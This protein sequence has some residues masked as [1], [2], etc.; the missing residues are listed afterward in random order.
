MKQK[1]HEKPINIILEKL[2]QV[3]QQ[4]VIFLKERFSGF[5]SDKE[6]KKFLKKN[7]SFL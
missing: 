2:A 4:F 3:K 6:I 7:K 5:Q 1:V